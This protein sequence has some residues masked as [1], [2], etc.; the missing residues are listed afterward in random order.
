ME[1]FTKTVRRDLNFMDYVPILFISAKTGQRVDQVM[2]LALQVQE[3]RLARLSTSKIND[4]IQKAIDY[5]P[6]PSHAGQQLKIYYG[7]QVRSNPPTFVL[8]VNNP[9]LMHFSYMRF[10][11]NRIRAEYGFLGTP[12]KLAAKGHND[13]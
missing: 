6:P 10:L 11:E 13:K 2:P 12:I 4:I 7:T 1:N 8:F 5:Q 3:E 9:T